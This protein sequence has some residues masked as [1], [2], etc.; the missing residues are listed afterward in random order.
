MALGLHI[1]GR[2][3]MALSMAGNQM[4]NAVT[5]GSPYETVSSRAAHARD[6]GSKVGKTV[7]AV[8]GWLDP[9]DQHSPQGNHCDIAEKNHDYGR[10]NW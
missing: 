10:G 6:H 5:G 1:V 8:F 9:R 7:C 4:V 2:Y 3:L